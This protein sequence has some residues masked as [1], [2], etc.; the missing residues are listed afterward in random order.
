MGRVTIDRRTNQEWSP[1]SLRLKGYWHGERLEAHRLSFQ[2]PQ[3]VLTR[4][5]LHTS[6]K[7]AILADWASDA[8]AVENLRNWRKLP[9]PSALVLLDDIR[10]TLRVLD[11][12]TLH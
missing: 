10:G 1:P 7:R 4:T 8:C 3:E 5:A 2:A 9:Q 11:R 6:K 12:G